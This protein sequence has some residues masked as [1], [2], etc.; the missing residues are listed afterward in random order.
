MYKLLNKFIQN[1]AHCHRLHYCWI[2]E[3]FLA[4][5]SNIVGVRTQKVVLE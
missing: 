4:G 5:H 3:I 1:E 2:I